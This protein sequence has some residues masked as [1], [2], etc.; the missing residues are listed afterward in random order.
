MLTVNIVEGSRRREL[1][2]NPVVTWKFK[3]ST[4]YPRCMGVVSE[5]EYQTIDGA[6][7]AGDKMLKRIIEQAEEEK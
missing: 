2:S 6:I 1:F 7:T 5:K 3:I 4:G